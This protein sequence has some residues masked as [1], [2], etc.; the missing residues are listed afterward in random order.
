MQTITSVDKTP[1]AFERRGTGPP[2]VLVHGT[3][4]DHTRWKPLLPQLEALFT[5]YAVDRRGRG[6]SGDAP[7]YTIEREFDDIAAVV[8]S[9]GEP[10]MLLGHSYGAVCSL[11][12]SLRTRSVR[13]L[14]LYEPPIRT[15]ES[16]YPPETVG[17]LQALLDAGDRDGVV[18]T[19]FRDVVRAPE[20]ELRMLRSLPN[21]AAR[22]AA[23]NTIPR[24]IRINDEYRFEPGRFSALRVPTL[25]LL[26]GSSRAVFKDAIEAVR[27]ALPNA[28]VAVMPGQQHTAMNTAPD[29]FLREVLGFLR[30]AEP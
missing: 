17:R 10:V 15:T 16:I 5:V 28:R 24:E 14:V 1:I 3:T 21:W 27:V 26:G 8:D 2:L 23:A 25:L 22:V 13:K 7:S 4:A 19:F 20:E 30:E 18:T 11:E 29:L 6:G 9:I 12:A